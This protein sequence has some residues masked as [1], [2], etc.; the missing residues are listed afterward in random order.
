MSSAPLGGWDGVALIWVTRVFGVV[1]HLE[2]AM[3][4]AFSLGPEHENPKR[5]EKVMLMTDYPI[6][7]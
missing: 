2:T 5:I 7:S 1:Q 6:E 3:G 4:S